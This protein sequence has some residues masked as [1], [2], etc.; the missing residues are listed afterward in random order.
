MKYFFVRDFAR[1]KVKYFYEDTNEVFK[2]SPRWWTHH[3]GQYKWWGH[4]W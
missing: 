2:H 1:K 4:P 3:W